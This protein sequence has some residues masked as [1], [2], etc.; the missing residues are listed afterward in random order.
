MRKRC[1]QQFG[2]TLTE[3]IIAVAIIA[4]LA[5]VAVPTYQSYMLKANRSDATKTLL[6]MQLAQEK[7]RISNTTY[8]SLAQVW[9]GVTSSE[10]GH[11]TL[12]ISGNTATSYTLTATAVGKQAN[13]TASG[14][15]CAA[16]VLTYANGTTTKTPAAC[17]GN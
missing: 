12:G 7:Y 11:Y 9:G 1:D 8:G 13:D 2:F 14:S 15:S 10:H 17:W 6:A 16:M 4:I 5:A 3:I